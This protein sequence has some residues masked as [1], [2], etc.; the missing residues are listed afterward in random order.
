LTEGLGAP[1]GGAGAA[2]GAGA[3]PGAAACAGSGV[4]AQTSRVKPFSSRHLLGWEH[5]AGCRAVG[6]GPHSSGFPDTTSSSSRGNEPGLAQLAGRVPAVQRG[7]RRRQRQTR[8]SGTR[9]Q[10]FGSCKS[11]ERIA[12][13]N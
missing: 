13:V 9:F 2:S 3:R 4:D 6:T 11:K 1:A 10:A 12:D 8:A 7:G 5:T